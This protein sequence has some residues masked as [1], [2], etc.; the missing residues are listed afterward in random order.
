MESINAL[1]REEILWVN[2]GLPGVWHPFKKTVLISNAIAAKPC[3]NF[4]VT[5]QIFPGFPEVSR[6]LPGISGDSIPV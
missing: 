5:I 6:R 3:V 4:D 1:S 2:V